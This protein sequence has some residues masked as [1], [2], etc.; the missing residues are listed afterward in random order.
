MY[1]HS[2]V[3]EWGQTNLRHFPWRIT[4]NPYEILIAE[5]MLHRTRA[6]QVEKVYQPFIKKYQDFVSICKSDQKIILN[7]IAYLGLVWRAELLHDLSCSIV[8]NYNGKIPVEKEELLN[9][10][11]I[12]PYI[13]SAFLCFAYGK[14][15]PLLD[16]NTVRVIGRIFGLK[17][18]DSSRRKKNF[19]DI[20]QNLVKNGECRNF[21][22]SLI[23]FADALCKTNNPL[24]EK[25]FL[26]DICYFFRGGEE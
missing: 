11:G 26:K 12:G 17:I 14:P 5:I 24:C 13:A 21:S 3:L 16:T 1:I 19:R 25:C 2:K 22:L 23:D 20:M 8:K 9:L 6:L 18:T 7:E 15:E 4:S 10:P